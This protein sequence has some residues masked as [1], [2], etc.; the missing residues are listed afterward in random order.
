MIADLT[1]GEAI[2]LERFR[3]NM[4]IKELADL[5][6]ISEVTISAYERG[7]VAISTE[8]LVRICNILGMQLDNVFEPKK[9]EEPSAGI[10]EETEGVIE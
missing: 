4:T 2:H 6:G 7:N 3:R 1:I 5:T 9:K 10:F 8:K